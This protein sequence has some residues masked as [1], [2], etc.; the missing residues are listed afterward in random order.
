MMEEITITQTLRGVGFV[1]TPTTQTLSGVVFDNGKV[2]YLDTNE[3]IC[4]SESEQV[5]ARTLKKE[6]RCIDVK[7]ERK[8]GIEPNHEPTDT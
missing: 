8:L 4:A 2:A 1:T 6:P 3:V 7:I 5:L